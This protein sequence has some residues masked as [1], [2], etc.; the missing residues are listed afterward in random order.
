MMEPVLPQEVVTASLDINALL[1]LSRLLIESDDP[2]F[3]FNNL[4]LTLMG[5]FGLGRAAV[6]VTDVSDPQLFRV[7]I[8]KGSSGELARLQFRQHH[9]QGE[10]GK[11]GLDPD[12]EVMLERN[13]IRY[14]LPLQFGERTFGIV[15]LGKPLTNRD[16]TQEDLSYAALVR[17]IAAIALEGCNAR[18]SLRHA[19]R[20]L[21]RRVH[22]LRSLF[23]ASQ[24]FNALLDHDGILR[25]L[26]YTLMGEMTISKYAVALKIGQEYRFAVNRFRETPSAECLPSLAEHGAMM[27][28]SEA[29][30]DTHLA[31]FYRLGIRASVPMEMQGETR[32]MLLIGQR[33]NQTMDEEDL[34]YLGA[35]ASLA[36]GGL[37][38][39]RLLEEMIEKNRLEEDLRIAAEIQK[40]LLPMVLP[41]VPGYQIAA[42][43]IPT[44][45]VG[46][47]CYDAIELGEGRVLV[48]VADVSGK[49]TPASLLMAN[50]QAALRA[51]AGLNLPLSELVARVNDIINDNTSADKFI[52]AFFGI[53]DPKEGTF[54][55]VNAGHN[56][57]YHFHQNGTDALDVGGLILGIM[58]TLIP[59]QIGQVTLELGDMVILYTDGVTEAM[60]TQREEYGDDRL[61]ALFADF[62]TIPADQAVERARYDIT[63]HTRGAAQSDDITLLV[64]KRN[65]STD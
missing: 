24:E 36:I 21:E 7:T 26:G 31:E 59:Y 52:T 43:T 13:H 64:V 4:L 54:T 37:E 55:Y 49:G 53:L 30:T 3:I 2:D 63:L 42:R 1:E 5:K 44:Q 19:N 11:F 46:G 56:P 25:L 18:G 60:S 34:E 9:T 47:D 6:A 57:P 17:T 10:D 28:T 35:L 27:F 39:S 45:Q 14:A 20:K 62:D 65:G 61:K 38:T 22:R 58:P 8:I 16:L 23:E 33:L 50:F 15:L 48:S 12:T 29:A 51:L 40:G 41:T 32:G